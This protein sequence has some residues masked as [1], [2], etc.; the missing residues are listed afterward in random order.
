M[1]ALEFLIVM[2][3]KPFIGVTHRKQLLAEGYK[4]DPFI[5]IIAMLS[6]LAILVL[7]VLL[8]AWLS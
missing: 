5:S 6:G 1:S 2:L 7:F 3:S 8:V 4:N